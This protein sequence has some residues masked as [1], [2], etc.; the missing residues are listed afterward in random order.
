MLIADFKIKV[1]NPSLNKN[2]MDFLKTV[3][4][5]FEKYPFRGFIL[6]NDVFF[7]IE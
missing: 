3:K 4:G 7:V 1:I 5:S 6:Y 2:C